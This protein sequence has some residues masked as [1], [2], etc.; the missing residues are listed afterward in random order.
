MSSN[1]LLLGFDA[2]EMWRG[3]KEDLP[4]N[5]EHCFFLRQDVT[6]Q[7]SADTVLWTSLFQG[8]EALPKPQWIGPIHSLWEDLQTL[9]THLQHVQNTEI[10]P[11][12]II[13]ITLRTDQLKSTE[14]AYWKRYRGAELIRPSLVDAEWELLGYDVA[15][16][17]LLSGLTSCAFDKGAEVEAL[18]KKFNP[19]LNT[20]HLFASIDS[21]MEFRALSDKRVPE[22]KPFFVF[23]LWLIKKEESQNLPAS[24]M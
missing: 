7:L 8:D 3:P 10:K 5:D 18:R 14:L 24:V 2:R 12:W 11:Y 13:A 22:H 1:D 21:A 16:Q 9:E 20:Y 23:G 17:W 15:D 4:A 6:K 19:T